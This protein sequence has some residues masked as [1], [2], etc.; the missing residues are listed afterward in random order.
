MQRMMKQWTRC[1]R[2]GAC[3]EG[4]VGSWSRRNDEQ[5]GLAVAGLAGGVSATEMRK[6]PAFQ[7]AGS[8]EAGGTA[9]AVQSCRARCNGGRI[10]APAVQPV[11][12]ASA[13]EDSSQRPLR[14]TGDRPGTRQ[15]RVMLLDARLT[16]GA[17]TT[18]GSTSGRA[19]ST[20]T[21][22]SRRRFAGLSAGDNDG[23]G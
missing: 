3:C 14:R 22:I 19:R 23:R 7:P 4:G 11:V 13:A 2:I 5:V 18:N 16:G 21:F 1:A 10:R 12:P 15:R 17:R 20:F 6:A 8:I 9:P